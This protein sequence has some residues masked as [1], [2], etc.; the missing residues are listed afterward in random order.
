MK[1]LCFSAAILSCFSANSAEGTSTIAPRL[2]AWEV[3]SGVHQYDPKTDR[4]TRIGGSVRTFCMTAGYAAKATSLLNPGEI[5]QGEAN[6]LGMKCK[7]EELQQAEG[8][9]SWSMTCE[10]GKEMMTVAKVSNAI[11]SER[12]VLRTENSVVSSG[13]VLQSMR[14]QTEGKYVGECTPDLPLLQP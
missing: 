14:T 7:I 13:K 10:M 6:R 1:A 4:E 11:S 2:G 8:A 12:L 5:N 9:A 3:S